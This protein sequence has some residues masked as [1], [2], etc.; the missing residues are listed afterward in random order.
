MRWAFI[1]IIQVAG[2]LLRQRQPIKQWWEHVLAQMVDELADGVERLAASWAARLNNPV[3]LVYK[4][5]EVVTVNFGADCGEQLRLEHDRL[6]IKAR[7]ERPAQ[8][9]GHLEATRNQS[10]G[11]V[12]PDGFITMS[13]LGSRMTT[14][15]LQETQMWSRG[16]KKP[17]ICPI[18]TSPLS[19]DHGNEA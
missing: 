8:I 18:A 13:K 3:S 17:R 11:K 9:P 5:A 14:C 15:P 12:L 4:M 16:A 2:S 6:R 1:R 7:G 19:I 10:F